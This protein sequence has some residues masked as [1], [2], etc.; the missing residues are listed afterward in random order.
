[1]MVN[2]GA[3]RFSP[4]GAAGLLRIRKLRERIHHEGRR[5][6]NKEINHGDH[7]AHGDRKKRRKKISPATITKFLFFLCALRALCGLNSFLHLL[8]GMGGIE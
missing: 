2:A 6:K 5:E 7:G 1:M 8:R 4:S 3:L